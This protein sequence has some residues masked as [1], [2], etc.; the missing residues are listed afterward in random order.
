VGLSSETVE[1]NIRNGRE[2]LARRSIAARE[3]A[4]ETT[5]QVIT[6]YSSEVAQQLSALRALG[7]RDSYLV[8]TNLSVE[9]R[10]LG[11][12]VD[13]PWFD[14]F[15]DVL[16][17]GGMDALVRWINEQ[18]PKTIVIDAPTSQLAQSVPYQTKHLSEIVRRTSAYERVRS[19]DGWVFYQRDE[20]P[21]I[22]DASPG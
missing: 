14:P 18:G 4:L 2:F 12:N 19:E 13:F 17:V 22:T 1:I 21:Q 6:P 5:L 8:L 15:I 20:Q 10:T 16:T 11:F 7:P 9:A 3:P